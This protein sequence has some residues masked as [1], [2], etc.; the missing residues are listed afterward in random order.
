MCKRL[1]VCHFYPIEGYP[2]VQNLLTYLNGNKN[3]KVTCIT[4]KGSFNFS[5]TYENIKIIRLGTSN[6]TRFRSIRLALSYLLYNIVG[7]LIIV[8]KS[9]ASILYYESISALPALL[10]KQLGKRTK[11]FIHYH[12]YT[13]PKEYNHGPKLPKLIHQLERKLYTKASWLS[14]TNQDRMRFFCDDNGLIPNKNFH[15]SPNYPPL[16]WQ[17]N[18]LA[19]SKKQSNDLLKLVYVGYSLNDNS[20]YATEIIKWVAHH[21]DTMQ[22]AFHLINTP[23]SYK[24]MVNELGASNIK[25]KEAVSYQNLPDILIQYDVGLILYKGTT[26]NYEYNAPNKLFEY[27]A[28]GLDVWYPDVLQ[29]P[30]PYNTKNTYPKVVPINFEQLDTFNGQQAIDLS[31]CTYQPSTYFCE[32]VYMEL[33]DEI[34]S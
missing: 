1:V 27:L 17:K 32:E 19:K 7:S 3:V 34:V 14:H 24:A 23:E 21:K 25:F 2:P 29:G 16:L 15:I 31:D 9:P 28:C 12:E 30:Q 22:L 26:A 4:T 18:T 8:L 13:S 33:V 6:C 11:L 10:L 5:C 20:M